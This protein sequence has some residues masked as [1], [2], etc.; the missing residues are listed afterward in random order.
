MKDSN[1]MFIVAWSDVEVEVQEG[2]REDVEETGPGPH[3]HH[4]L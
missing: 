1:A 3:K 2:K 4:E